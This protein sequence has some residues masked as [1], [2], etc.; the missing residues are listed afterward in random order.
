MRRKEIGLEKRE[1]N[2]WSAA[3]AG[4]Q[5]LRPTVHHALQATA[6]LAAEVRLGATDER[7]L[8]LTF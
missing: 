8:S 2:K 1:G 6:K 3:P 4:R 5:D 7:Q